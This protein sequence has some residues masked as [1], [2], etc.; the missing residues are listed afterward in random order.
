[1]KNKS[2]Q[3]LNAPPMNPFDICFT[4][5]ICM[6]DHAA[7]YIIFI[8]ENMCYRKAKPPV[9]GGFYEIL[10]NCRFFFNT[11]AQQKCLLS[12]NSS[13]N[14]IIKNKIVQLSSKKLPHPLSDIVE[15]SFQPLS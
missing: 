7:F 13:R 8:P 9:K 12:K 11:A 6:F 15:A 14:R 4:S 2:A 5:F 3:S 10:T 1:M